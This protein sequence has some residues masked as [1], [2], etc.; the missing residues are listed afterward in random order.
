MA[1]FN[2]IK[3]KKNTVSLARIFEDFIEA[4]TPV[5][6]TELHPRKIEEDWK[7]RGVKTNRIIHI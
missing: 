7:E 5:K 6:M 3:K 1:S 4:S 2:H